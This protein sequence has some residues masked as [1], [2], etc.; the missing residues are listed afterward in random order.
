MTGPL[1][2]NWGDAVPE[3]RI[4]F[5]RE[6]GN[7]CMEGRHALSRPA[8][9]PTMALEC[10]HLFA[11]EEE[12]WEVCGCL[13]RCPAACSW[14]RREYEYAMQLPTIDVDVTESQGL[15]PLELQQIWALVAHEFGHV[16]GMC[17]SV[18]HMQIA[19]CISAVLNMITIGL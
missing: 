19:Y 15:A 9:E 14:V 13:N 8:T 4:S 18:F 17:K 10:L 3:I 1:P 6:G 11:T 2:A 7:Y 5:A 16:L 12:A